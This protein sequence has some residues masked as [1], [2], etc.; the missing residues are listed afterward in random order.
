MDIPKIY[1]AGQKKHM[2]FASALTE[3]DCVGGQ[4]SPSADTYEEARQNGGACEKQKRSKLPHIT[5]TAVLTLFFC[6][7]ALSVT[8]TLI[9][10]LADP[11]KAAVTALLD[12]EIYGGAFFGYSYDGGNDASEAEDRADEADIDSDGNDT[13]APGTEAAPSDTDASEENAADETFHSIVRLDLS[14]DD[15]LSL[16]NETDYTPDMAS[17]ASSPLPTEALDN[18]QNQYGSTA[19]AVLIIHTHGTESYSPEGADGLGDDAVFRSDDTE[20]NV[21][22][23]G[24]VMAKTLSLCGVGVLHSTV[25]YDKDDYRGAYDASAAAVRDYLES[26]PSIKYIFDVHRDSVTRSDGSAAAPTTELY[27]KSSAQVMLVVGTDEGG[28][29][30]YDWEANLTLAAHIQQS[31]CVRFPSLNR[32][33]NLRRAA[34]N[35]GIAPGYLLIEVGSHASSLSEAKRG[36]AAAAIAIA[37]VIGADVS[38]VD[39]EALISLAAE[40]QTT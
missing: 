16:Q 23:V 35:Q 1:V 39:E 30:E 3:A 19:P 7:V 4:V 2:V 5:I 38:S 9:M 26:Y 37:G 8:G 40:D 17:L 20:E 6:A 14:T 21:V 13:V 11:V 22:A 34:F 15:A 33:I 12:R 10:N 29:A 24:S 18:I 31:L 36:A 32:R 28:A 27:G 25:M